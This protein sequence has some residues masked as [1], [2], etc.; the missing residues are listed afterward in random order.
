[1]ASTPQ[2][3]TGVLGLPNNPSPASGPGGPP[4]GGPPSMP[5]HLQRAL[6]SLKASPVPGDHCRDQGLSCARGS[7]QR[8]GPP[9]FAP[10]LSGLLNEY[11]VGCTGGILKFQELGISS[12]D[13]KGGNPLLKGSREGVWSLRTQVSRGPIYLCVDHRGLRL[14]RKEKP[15]RE[16]KRERSNGS[17]K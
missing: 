5:G 10:K 15:N 7:L 14:G 8:P 17:R 16:I 12:R 9:S 4:V 3:D 6:H 11:N 13:E 1:M 2:P